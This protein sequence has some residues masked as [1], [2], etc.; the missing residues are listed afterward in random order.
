MPHIWATTLLYYLSGRSW[1]EKKGERKKKDTDVPQEAERKQL[2][3]GS[4]VFS[5]WGLM[6]ECVCACVCVC[7]LGAVSG[8]TV[9]PSGRELHQLRLEWNM[10][11]DWARRLLC[12]Q[13]IPVKHKVQNKVIQPYY[14]C[15]FYT[16]L[17]SRDL[18]PVF[19]VKNAAS[20]ACDKNQMLLPSKIC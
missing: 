2:S 10:T 12:D 5:E 3:R 19:L 8:V 20:E 11:P 4:S 6:P 15:F 16:Q 18:T 7:F 1:S 17:L 9:H 13:N 14:R